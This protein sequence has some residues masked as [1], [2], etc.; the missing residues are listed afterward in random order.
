MTLACSCRPLPAESVKR[1]LGSCLRIQRWIFA[2]R[3]LPAPAISIHRPIRLHMSASRRPLCAVLARLRGSHAPVL[4]AHRHGNQ[5]PETGYCCTLARATA[6]ETSAQFYADLPSPLARVDGTDKTTY[7]FQVSGLAP[8]ALLFPCRESRASSNSPAHA[9]AACISKI[10]I[11]KLLPLRIACNRLP[12]HSYALA[13]SRALY[14][15]LGR[16]AVFQA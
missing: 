5:S 9:P 15:V 16:V 13:V 4:P 12:I 7:S 2:P 10:W 14:A 1:L 8:R 11:H 6:R 3:P